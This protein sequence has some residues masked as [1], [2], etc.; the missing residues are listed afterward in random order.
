MRTS[1][2][3]FSRKSF[4]KSMCYLPT[5]PWRADSVL[6]DPPITASATHPLLSPITSCTIRLS[7][8]RTGLASSRPGF[9]AT[10]CMPPTSPRLEFRTPQPSPPPTL[11]TM[12]REDAVRVLF[13]PPN[14]A[15][16]IRS[17]A[18]EPGHSSEACS[19]F[20]GDAALYPST[21]TPIPSSTT[22]VEDWSQITLRC[23]W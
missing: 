6:L 5:Y 4:S 15:R 23:V 8:P 1:L 10:M 11:G 18:P 22:P 14:P 2:H 16:W 12:S 9:Q 21:A 13:L 7:Q 20:F 17:N 19:H 3:E